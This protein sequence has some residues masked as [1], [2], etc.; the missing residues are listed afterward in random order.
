M[1]EARKQSLEVL[2]TQCVFYIVK[3]SSCIKVWLY[4]TFELHR[5]I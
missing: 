5:D 1:R 2:T 3:T 4:H